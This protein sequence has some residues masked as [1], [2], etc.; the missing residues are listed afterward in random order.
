MVAVG[1]E[2]AVRKMA[3][4]IVG[5]ASAGTGISTDMAHTDARHRRRWDIDS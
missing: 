5:M 1:G 4:S 3:G 2:Q